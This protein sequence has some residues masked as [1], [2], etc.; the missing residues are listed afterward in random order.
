MDTSIKVGKLSEEFTGKLGSYL[1]IDPIYNFYPLYD[2][3][4]AVSH[5]KTLWH[6]GFKNGHLAGF[7]LIYH[8][9]T[10]PSIM[11]DG[12]RD[13][14]THLLD[15]VKIEEATF[16]LSPT[17]SDIV[18]N[19]FPIKSEYMTEI[20]S[21]R[22]GEEALYITHDVKLLNEDH[23]VDLLRLVR[24]WRPAPNDITEEE[25]E[26]TM[27]ELKRSDIYGIFTDGRLA[28]V[29][30]LKKLLPHIPEVCWIGRVFTSQK[31]RGR[32]F[33]ASLVSK[34]VEEA[35]EYESVRYVGLGVRS[36]NIPAKHLYMKVGF[37]K[38]RA[39]CWLNLNTEITP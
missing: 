33:A 25:V 29:V 30:Q 20:M 3:Y 39:R 16:H 24:E 4:D 23:A 32:G 5:R 13:V 2:L 14:V 38:Y 11:L 28:S 34:A 31:Y 35:F 37:K 8:G 7:L 10:P 9:E 1:R 27:D 17:L 15:I 18:K 36:D 21:L 6:I 19:K 22:K 26:K 12:D